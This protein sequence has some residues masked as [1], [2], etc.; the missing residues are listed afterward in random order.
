VHIVKEF[1]H[2]CCFVCTL[3]TIVCWKSS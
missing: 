2:K 1:Q 3:W